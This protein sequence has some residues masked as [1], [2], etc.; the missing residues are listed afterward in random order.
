MF[1]RN[2]NKLSSLVFKTKQQKVVQLLQFLFK[3]VYNKF[4]LFLHFAILGTL[5][6]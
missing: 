6:N 5:V 1:Q 4:L 2:E 3:F